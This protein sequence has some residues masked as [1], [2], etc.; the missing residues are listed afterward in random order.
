MKLKR[1]LHALRCSSTV[2]NQLKPMDSLPIG[3]QVAVKGCFATV[4]KV[5]LSKDQHGSPIYVHTV[6]YPDGT[7]RETNYSFIFYL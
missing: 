7:E 5:E 1:E 3:R 2:W 4:V 6:R